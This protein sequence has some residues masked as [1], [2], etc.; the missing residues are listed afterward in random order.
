[1]PSSIPALANLYKET[2]LE[3]VLPFWEHQSIDREQGGFF[4]CLDRAGNVYDTDKFIWLQN[5]QV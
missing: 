2:L 5:R 1:M 4:T 3:N